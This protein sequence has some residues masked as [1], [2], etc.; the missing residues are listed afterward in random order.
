M[1]CE[2]ISLWITVPFGAGQRGV[3]WGFCPAW[4][5]TGTVRDSDHAIARK[6]LSSKDL[7]VPH[8]AGQS[9][10]GPTVPLSHPL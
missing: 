10:T 9:G 1:N 7:T 8:V 5:N 2:S 3:F 6:A 4:S